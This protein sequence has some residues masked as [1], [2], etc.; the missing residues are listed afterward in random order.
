[1]TFDFSSYKIELKVPV[2]C[3]M[4]PLVLDDA[5]QGRGDEP[6]RRAPAPADPVRAANLS[7]VMAESLA[8]SI[9]GAQGL[10]VL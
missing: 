10:R 6:T 3:F 1:M 4:R 5:F 8:K 9:G 2:L 7:V